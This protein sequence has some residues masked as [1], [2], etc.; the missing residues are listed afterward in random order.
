[1]VFARSWY[2]NS[3]G[4][5]PDKAEMERAD[6]TEKYWAIHSSTMPPGEAAKEI[7]K[8]IERHFPEPWP[9][10]CTII[11][12]IKDLALPGVSTRGRPRK[13]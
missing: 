5:M 2:I 9:E 1:M 4:E 3:R 7:R 11:E 12:W 13:K 10:I 8:Q 6:E